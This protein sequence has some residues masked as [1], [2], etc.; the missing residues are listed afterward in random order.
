MWN[1]FEIPSVI[2]KSGSFITAF[3]AVVVFVAL[4]AL[5]AFVIVEMIERELKIKRTMGLIADLKF[6]CILILSHICCW[7]S[8][9]NFHIETVFDGRLN[10]IGKWI[11]MWKMADK[12]S[13][14]MN[15]EII[16]PKK[17]I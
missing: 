16:L 3:G 15:C 6:P 11:K 4:V 12:I 5:V 2:R 7:F 10:V 8:F 9:G 13:A 17:G 1:I 14:E